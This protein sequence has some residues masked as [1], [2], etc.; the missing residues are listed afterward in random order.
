MLP[1]GDNGLNHSWIIAGAPGGGRR[2]ADN[3][4]DIVRRHGEIP[5]DRRDPLEGNHE[6]TPLGAKGSFNLLA[7]PEHLADR[8]KDAILPPVFVLPS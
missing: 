8:S 5:F 7:Q 2:H 6:T 4:A 1:T 3:R